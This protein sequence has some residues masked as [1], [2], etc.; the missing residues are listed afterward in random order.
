MKK[1]LA[2]FL[3]ILMLT[4]C[5]TKPGNTENNK[6]GSSNVD[7]KKVVYTSFYPIEFAT[8]EIVKDKMDVRSVIPAGVEV[9]DWEPSL[10]DMEQLKE[11]SLVLINGLELESWVEDAKKV[12]DDD[13]IVDLS[14]G[15]ELIKADEDDHD[16]DHEDDH[17]HDHDHEDDHDHD[18][19]DDHDHDHEDDHDHDHEEGHGHH[20]H[21]HGEFDPHVWLSLRNFQIVSKNIC[22]AVSKIDPENKEFYEQNFEELKN[23]LDE[24]DKKYAG[25]FENYK[26][27]HIIVPHEAFAYMARDYDLVQIPI[28]NLT[29]DSEPDLKTIAN[30][31]D[32]AKSEGI[33]TVFYEGEDSGKVPQTIAKEIGGKAMPIHTLEFIT[34]EQ[35][36]N[37]ENYLTMMEDNFK[38]ILESFK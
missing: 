23:K 29:S 27:K 5:A 25:D 30:I 32:T 31:V 3:S 38:N 17:D 33:K 34:D 6:E 21:H 14:G 19:E 13:K 37:G 1:I 12:V 7:G 10:K 11:S 18:H 16:H 22:E 20:H 36:K 9:H 26:G 4:S 8:K 15:I 28:E 35:E 24:L 2:I